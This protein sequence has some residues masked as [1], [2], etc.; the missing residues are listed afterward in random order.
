MSS[1]IPL[2]QQICAFMTLQKEDIYLIICIAYV[3]RVMHAITNFIHA[4]GN[5]KL[6]HLPGKARPQARTLYQAVAIQAYCNKAMVVRM[7][8]VLCLGEWCLFVDTIGV[9][10]C[11]KY[12]G[13]YF[14]L[15]SL[16]LVEF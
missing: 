15:I 4:F 12:F 5:T 2:L 13:I 6:C 14:K 16:C 3:K 11:R 7:V 9:L 1:C 8:H 10:N